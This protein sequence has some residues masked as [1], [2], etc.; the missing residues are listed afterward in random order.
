MR[1]SRRTKSQTSRRVLSVVTVLMAVLG[2]VAVSGATAAADTGLCGGDSYSACTSGGYTD[3][4]YG[5]P[6]HYNNSYWGAI[7]G[8]NCTNYVAYVEQTVN[9][10]P[11]PPYQ[12]GNADTW[13]QNAGAHGVGTNST[14]AAG[15]VAWWGDA[16]VNGG[17]VAYVES[18]NAGGSIIISEDSYASGPFDWR[19]ISPGSNSWPDG[20]IHFKDLPAGG[21]G[22][23]NYLIARVGPTVYGK[24]G[25]TDTWSTLASGAA[26]DVQAAG[27]RIAFMDN[28][29]TLW[30]KD[31]LGGSWY[32]ETSPVNQ[33]V[34]TPDL[35]LAR[36]DNTVYGKQS[37]GDSWVTLTA[38]SATDV[39]AA[40]TRIAFVDGSGNLFAKDGLGG[41]WY[42]EIGST[43]QYLATTTEPQ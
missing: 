20:F 13:Y 26:A 41:T 9:G 32:Q 1:D 42:Q 25:L 34:V 40:G 12:L 11:A 33:Y 39:R 2:C 15:A 14:P 7:A 35:L 30:A 27:T 23:T 4:G 24:Q 5:V 38:G 3:H 22:A 29:G 28:S 19:I 18:V 8:H 43:S 21:S 16:K 10:A 6:A 31:T 36:V 17:H 37:L